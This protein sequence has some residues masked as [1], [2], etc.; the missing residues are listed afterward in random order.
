MS[1]EIQRILACNIRDNYPDFDIIISDEEPYT[2]YGAND[3][4]KILNMTSIRS[5]IRNYN[6]TEKYKVNAHTNGGNQDLIFM[7]YT[8]LLK[9]LTKSRK[10]YLIDF[11]KIC[12][13]MILVFSISFCFSTS[14]LFY[15]YP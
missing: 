7:T 13:I 9:L 1:K 15:R 8:G 5:I 14:F 3:I 4:A 6:A 11:C 12:N 10:P 2:L